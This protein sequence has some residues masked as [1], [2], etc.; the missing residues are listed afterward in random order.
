MRRKERKT[1]D[2]TKRRLRDR[3]A[4]W[5]ISPGGKWR[6]KIKIEQ[7]Q[8][9]R[10]IIL[11]PVSWFKGVDLPEGHITPWELFLY[12]LSA[13][14]SNITSGFAGR[15]DFLF[16]EYYKIAPN[17]ISVGSV[18]SSLW[19][20]ANDPVLGSYM[21][22]K[23]W[24]PQQWRRIM[25]I[26]AVTGSTLNVIK[27]LDGGMSDWQHIAL[28]V[29]C[30]CIQDI[31]GTLSSVSDQKMR[32]GISP[33]S[34]QRGRIQVWVSVGNSIGYP[35][36]TI[37]M[38]LMGLRDVFHLNDYQ[39][40][41]MGAVFMLPFNIIASYM[42]TFIKQR[43]N[44]RA[45]AP[46]NSLPLQ[47]EVEVNP[48]EALSEEDLI[49]IE[50]EMKHREAAKK[51][52]LAKRE[53]KEMLAAMSRKER[54]AF[55][56]AERK[57]H[58]EKFARGEFELDP[59]TGEPKLTLL[60]SFAVTKHNKYFIVNTIA[61]FIT[62]FTPSVDPLLIYRYLVPRFTLFGKEISGEMMWLVHAQVAGT[63]VTFTKPFSRQLVNKVGGPLKTNKLCHMINASLYFLRFLVGCNKFWKLFFN[64]IAEAA[65]YVVN[66]MNSVA[67]NMLNYE[68][69][70]YVEWKTGLR[71]EGV[72]ASVSGLLSKIVTNN[73]GTVTGNAFLAWTGY[74]GGY[75]D[76]G[77][78]VPERFRKYMWPMY[79]L[80]SVFDQMVYLLLR[81]TV[82]YSP[83]DSHRVEEALKERRAAAE[84]ENIAASE[85]VTVS[86]ESEG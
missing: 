23:R 86:S 36:S 34:Q 19:D 57:E 1:R 33:Y 50:E 14:L 75:I 80:A 2:G 74:E 70:D 81:S 76:E 71:T 22:R 15:Q 40:I 64:M 73:I 72:T 46:T 5:V 51:A 82:K 77:G 53:R 42:V 4:D 45:G 49:P 59:E 28:L 83:E 26:S 38:L 35:L 32:A 3:L 60:E 27:M 69:L 47:P 61:G 21:D 56:A 52:E 8:E 10:K 66:D 30:N 65:A 48:E 67:E 13:A 11:D 12:A 17:K 41:V 63:P 6:Q 54:K 43:V 58:R 84:G 7:R 20:A 44:F 55:K 62:V 25:R 16:K 18:I 31:I 24:G 39:I 37:P 79:T 29:A 78:E 9:F 68:M 85:S